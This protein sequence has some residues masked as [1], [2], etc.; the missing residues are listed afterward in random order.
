MS[1]PY[2]YDGSSVNP[3][4]FMTNR[5]DST[6]ETTAAQMA[7][8]TWQ[9]LGAL[10]GIKGPA[11]ICDWFWDAAHG[12]PRPATELFPITP[13]E[14]QFVS[15][16]AAHPPAEPSA[17]AKEIVDKIFEEI[18]DGMSLAEDYRT[19]VKCAEIVLRKHFAAPP[20]GEGDKG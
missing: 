11:R 13:D 15:R 18:H 2:G 19:S 4:A 9:V 12:E 1:D 7:W 10:F 5:S 6:Q 20:S 3:D 17:L 14:Q 8:I 16:L